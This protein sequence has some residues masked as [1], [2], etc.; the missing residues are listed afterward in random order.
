VAAAAPRTARHRH[1]GI[2][3]HADDLRISRLQQRAG[4]ATL[5][6][7]DA[8]GS[9]PCTGWP[10]PRCGQPA[11]GRLLRAPRPGR[12]IAFRGRG[13]EVLLRRHDRWCAPSAAW[14]PC[15]AAAERR[16]PRGWRPQAAWRSR[17]PQRC[18]AGDR[19]AHRRPRQYRARRRTGPRTRRGRCPACGAPPARPAADGAG[20]RH[21]P[22]PAAAA[23]RLAREM[24][25]TYRALPHAGAAEL[26]ATVQALPRQAAEDRTRRRG[27][28]GGATARAGRTTIAAASSSP[29]GSAVR[30]AMAAAAPGAPELLLITARRLQ[31]LVARLHGCWRST[32]VMA[33]TCQD[34]A[35]A[36]R[37]AATAPRCPHGTRRACAA[38]G[39]DAAP[40]VL[41]GT[42]PAPPSRAHGAGRR[43]CARLVSLNGALLPLHAWP[44]A[45]SRAG[46][47]CWPQPWCRRL[48]AWRAAD[49]AALRR[50]IES[51]G[52][53]GRRGQ[54]LYG[55]WSRSRACRRCAGDDGALGLQPLQSA[56]PRLATPLHLVVGEQDRTVRRRIRNG[57]SGCCRQRRSRAASAARHGTWRTRNGA[58]GGRAAVAPADGRTRRR[59]DRR[60]AVP[61]RGRKSRVDSH[62]HLPMLNVSDFSDTT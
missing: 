28:T 56:L 38:G 48:F 44:A 55:G 58:G 6:V 34:T 17:W 15:P 10:R 36:H 26:S 62:A 18:L 60:A 7:I 21:S 16:W 24:D 57:C 61:A 20:R 33:S 53:L 11:A 39:M 40:S 9:S 41:V 35:S 51:T 13:A 25:A 32:R 29:T 12:V 43:A 37:R 5:F 3:V 14:P 27:W 19:A 47:A 42:R 31:P 30:A 50:L 54:A 22:Q 23:L 59:R 46:Q 8:S 49:P 45:S 2:H 52:R 4:T 1:A